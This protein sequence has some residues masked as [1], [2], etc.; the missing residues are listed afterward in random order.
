MGVV[1]VALLMG[2]ALGYTATE[3]LVAA[4]LCVVC[5]DFAS[6]AFPGLLFTE[7][8]VPVALAAWAAA[9]RRWVLT[10]VVIAVSGLVKLFPFA[11]VLAVLVPLL[12][13]ALPASRGDD[14]TAPRAR[15]WRLLAG[16]AVAVVVLGAVSAG[17]GGDWGEFVRKI[18]V[19]FHSRLNMANNVSL[20]ALLIAGGVSDRSPLLAAAALVAFVATAAMFWG[21]EDGRFLDALPRRMLVLSLATG[22]IVR[23]WL[24]YYVVLSFLLV[25]WVARRRPRDGAVILAAMAIV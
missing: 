19:E 2:G 11:L 22:L 1:L 14:R 8:W 3:R 5:M 15:A 25:P 4:T 7:V 17:S 9:Q 18:S 10:G 13:S 20:A 21:R 23:S 24:N 16:F 6:Y 12:R